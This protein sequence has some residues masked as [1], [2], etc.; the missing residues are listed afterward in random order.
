MSRDKRYQ[1][2]SVVVVLLFLAGIIYCG[3]LVSQSN[4]GKTQNNTQLPTSSPDFNRSFVGVVKG[5]DFENQTIS[6]VSTENAVQMD[7]RFN[8]GTDVRTQYDKIVSMKAITLGEIVDFTF[9]SKTNKLRSLKINKDAWSYENIK[10]MKMDS[11]KGV[12]QLGNSRYGIKEG[13]LYVGNNKIINLSD[14]SSKDQLTVKGIGEM[15]YS[16]IV[17]K[18]HGILR[19]TNIKD[20]VGGTVYV[21][22]STY[23]TVKGEPMNLVIREGSYKIVMQNG[24]LIGTKEVTVKRD[25]EITVDMS[26][27]KISK[28]RIGKVTFSISPYGADVYINGKAVDYS[29]PVSLNYGNHTIQVALSGYKSFSGILTVGQSTQEIEVNLVPDTS[30]DESSGSDDVTSDE[31][32]DDSDDI[33]LDWNSDQVEDTNTSKPSASATPS[34]SSSPAAS[35]SPTVKPSATPGSGTDTLHKITISKPEDVEVYIDD[36]YKGLAPVNFTKVLGSHTITLKK[37]GYKSKTYSIHVED[38]NENVF[39]TFDELVK[40]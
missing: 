16:I 17:T 34:A 30:K 25:E 4:K 5:L 15:V 18:G 36:V 9:D 1:A 10:K 14:L 3:V 33:V 21:G 23:K 28:A 13:L 20:F 7:F 32:K 11:D 31:D 37:D 22:A 35:A 27:F 40:E 39:Y 19:F 29:E 2:I 8:G 12:I 24:E 6:L 26:E 38:N